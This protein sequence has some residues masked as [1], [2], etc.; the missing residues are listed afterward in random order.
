MKKHLNDFLTSNQSIN[1]M[2]NR[3]HHSWPPC[4]PKA[5]PCHS[6]VRRS[7]A[8]KGATKARD[9]APWWLKRALLRW[10][11]VWDGTCRRMVIWK[12]GWTTDLDEVNYKTVTV[13][14]GSGFATEWWFVTRSGLSV[15][16]RTWTVA[17]KKSHLGHESHEMLQNLG[18]SR[19]LQLCH[20]TTLSPRSIMLHK[21]PS[22][23]AVP[24][25]ND[26]GGETVH[27]PHLF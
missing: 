8:A 17:Y 12:F 7:Q 15:V 19:A 23:L 26:T 21:F 1:H 16:I 27:L 24:H 2:K 20:V 10:P 4:R 25:T 3:H 22:D 9:T 18:Q 11:T 13:H 6:L 5:K 14:F